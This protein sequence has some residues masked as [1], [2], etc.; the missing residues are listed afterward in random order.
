[1][2]GSRRIP[3]RRTGPKAGPA[4]ASR[5]AGFP[6]QDMAKEFLS[7]LPGRFHLADAFFGTNMRKKPL[8]LAV[9]EL[10]QHVIETA[11]AQLQTQMV[12]SDVFESVALVEDGHLVIGQDAG[13]LAARRARSLK[14]RA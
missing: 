9:I 5:C 13:S 10:V 12:G 4:I 1:M 6:F 14:N 7:R 8:V 2:P 11:P 3:S